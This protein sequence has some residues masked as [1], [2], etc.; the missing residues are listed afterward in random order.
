MNGRERI[1]RAMRHE[2]PDRVPVMAQLSLGHYFLNSGLKPHEI[3]FSSEGFAEAL[4]R[5]QRRYAFDGIL[6]NLPGRPRDMLTRIQRIDESERGELIFWK[7]GHL[8]LLPW[9]DNGQYIYTARPDLKPRADFSTLDIDRLPISAYPGYLWGIYHTPELEEYPAEG[10]LTEIPEYF[11]DTIRAVRGK[12]AGEVSV[13]GEVF[14][15]Y[16]HFL[17]LFDYENAVMSL[18]ED[19][20]RV[21]QILARLTESAVAWAVAQAKA[22]VDAVLISSAF[23][24]AGFISPRMYKQFV[25]PYEREV[26]E[27]VKAFGVPVY[28]HTC[29]RI[30]DRLELMESSGTQGIDTLDP[31]PLGDVELADAKARVGRRIFLKGNLNSVA[32]LTQT[33]AEVREAVM[34]RLRVG[35]PG[36]GYILSSACSIA[37]HVEPWKIKLFA[38]LAET[39]GQYA[40]PV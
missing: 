24:G 11:T 14:S 31:L 10:A 9:D 23:A 2:L 32:L 25:V 38:A 26:T 28:T 1:A 7:N 18:V 6:I 19:P 13:H 30:G 8:T 33:E 3:W 40:Q 35:K 27:A 37:P 39:Y 21:H 4:V 17:E 22:G 20:E 34:E 16:T 36:G 29:G 12:I 15:P 5:L